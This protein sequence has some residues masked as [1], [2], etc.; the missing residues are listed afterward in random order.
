ME[1]WYVS[2]NS[3]GIAITV[4]IILS[5]FLKVLRVII[6]KRDEIYKNTFVR[7]IFSANK[8][9][10]A[11]RIFVTMTLI[12]LFFNFFSAGYAVGSSNSQTNPSTPQ[13][14]AKVAGTANDNSE[15]F[16]GL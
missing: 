4:V 10:W 6:E 16:R 9:V 13:V 7:N 11:Q 12:M 5:L 15:W 8:V 1:I 3:L 14:D 2:N